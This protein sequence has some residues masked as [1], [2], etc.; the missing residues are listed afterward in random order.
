[1]IVI[2]FGWVGDY[3]VVGVTQQLKGL[4]WTAF[5]LG[6]GMV[7]IIIVNDEDCQRQQGS[8]LV[9]AK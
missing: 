8:Q 4:S 9:T 5:A 3:D 1:V 7:L 2:V 6:L